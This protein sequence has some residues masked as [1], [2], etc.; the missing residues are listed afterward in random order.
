MEDRFLIRE[1][2]E[3]WA[4]WRDAGDWDR[5]ATVWHDD[6]WMMATWFQAPAMDFIARSRAG[7]DNGV[8]VLH[9]L[10][11]SSIDVVG[12]RAVAHTKMEINQRA[13]VHDVE[14]DVR[15]QGRFVDAL[16]KRGGRWGM[17]LRQPVY[18]LDAMTPVDPAGIVALDPDRLA[19]FPEGYRHLAYL[20]VEQ[21]MEVYSNMPGTRG[22]E[23]AEL[24]QRLAD[25][26][27]GRPNSCLRAAAA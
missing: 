8:K 2:I 5:F 16:E 25:W 15:C 13:M 23:I 21:G 3:N 11:G 10:G 26:L 27:A 19:R 4:V 12:H 20:Q 14:V 24:N 1:L 17:V 18:E 22:A 6:G 9:Q 7:F